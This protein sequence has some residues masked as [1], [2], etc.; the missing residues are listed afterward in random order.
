MAFAT[1]TEGRK[2]GGFNGNDDQ[3]LSNAA[4]PYV[5]LTPAGLSVRNPAYDPRNTRRR[6]RVR[7]G[8]SAIC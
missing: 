5:A 3:I 1:Y 7:S 6:F 8:E 2:S 4:Q